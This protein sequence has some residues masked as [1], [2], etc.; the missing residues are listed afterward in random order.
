MRVR[1]MKNG[2]KPLLDDFLL[3]LRGK[4]KGIDGGAEIDDFGRVQIMAFSNFVNVAAMDSIQEINLN[5][6]P[7]VLG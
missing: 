2:R 1:V 6:Y 5:P 4:P 3:G 7:T